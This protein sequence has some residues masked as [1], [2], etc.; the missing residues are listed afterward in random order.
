MSPSPTVNSL[1]HSSSSLSSDFGTPATLWLDPACL[2]YT[3]CT[4][5]P[6]SQTVPASVTLW[7]ILCFKSLSLLLHLPKSSSTTLIQIKLHFLWRTFPDFRI[8]VAIPYSG[9]QGHT[10]LHQACIIDPCKMEDVARFSHIQGTFMT[11]R[12]QNSPRETI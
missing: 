3:P 4:P 1:S 11:L 7:S 10:A 6:I 12:L 2:T 8:E 9:Y 5:P